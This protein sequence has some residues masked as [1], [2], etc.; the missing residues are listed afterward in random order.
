ML[1]PSL[2]L[3][4]VE[5]MNLKQVH[6][7]VHL[8]GNYPQAEQMYMSILDEHPDNWLCL[9]FLGTLF[10]Q[11]NRNGLAIQCFERAAFHKPH[12]A[13]V[14]NNLGTAYKR[15]NHNERAKVCFLRS[16]L[17]KKDAETFTNLST[18]FINEGCPDFG[19]R[20]SDLSIK[21]SPNN[22]QGHWNRSLI[23]LEQGKY[24]EGFDE[25]FWGLRSK[26]RINRDYNAP[27][28]RGE[29]GKRVVV[30]GEQ[31]IGD[32]IMFASII[33][34]LMRRSSGVILDCHPRLKGLFERD[35]INASSGGH[36]CEL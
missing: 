17:L 31:G 29:E 23:L 2:F 25:Y 34:D 9:F 11:T 3:P 27:I 5:K 24:G 8:K 36:W 30:W 20:Y 19:A 32:E 16:S 4:G 7:D 12:L 35:G 13:E 18:V 14:W 1:A 21:M 22:I 6:E 33:P 28:Y 26:D 10:L 15:E